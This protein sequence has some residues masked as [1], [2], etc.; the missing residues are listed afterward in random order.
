MGEEENGMNRDEIEVRLDALLSS[1]LTRRRFLYGASV[2]GASAGSVLLAACSSSQSSQTATG[3]SLAVG[4]LLDATGAINIYGKVMIDATNFAIDSI[5]RKG[6]VLGKQLKLVSYDAQSDND[7]YSQYANTLILNDKAT[8]IM[9]GITSASREAIRPLMDRSKQLYFYNEQY[10]GGVCDKYVF[11][12]GVVPSQQLSTLISYAADTGSKK[13]YTLAADYNYGHIS[14]DWVKFYM[15]K[16]GGLSAAGLDFFPLDVS[17]FATAITKVQRSGADTVMSL[18]V[19]GNHIAFYRQFAAAGLK[20]KIRI[21]SPTYGL[22][23]EQV[24]LSPAEGQGIVVAYPYFQELTNSTNKQWVADWRSRYGSDYPYV[25]DSANAVWTGWHLWAMA[26]NKAGT[27]DLDPVVKA[28]E[29]GLSYDSPE[30]VVKLDPKSHHVVHNVNVGVGNANHGFDI[31]K[32]YNAISPD[33][34]S[35]CDL[36]GNP[37]QH[38]QLTPSVS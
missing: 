12:T 28:L 11:C 36:I 37:N 32:T 20:D 17:D 2:A 18:L 35:Q 4:S 6:G 9:G 29:S 7:K 31:V 13:I 27:A 1:P 8:V 5:N 25:T 21:V 26:A 19:G 38:T 22:G 3:G 33:P 14:S 10:E 16:Q 30:G 23:N 34:Q 15:G 24:V